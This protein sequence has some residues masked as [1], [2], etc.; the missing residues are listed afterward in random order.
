MEAV[1]LPPWRDTGTRMWEKLPSCWGVVTRL[2]CPGCTEGLPG[3]RPREDCPRS[4]APVRVDSFQSHLR[5]L[6]AD[7]LRQ[8]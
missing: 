6:W 4:S 8:Q 3:I 5:S 1:L 7:G 2:L